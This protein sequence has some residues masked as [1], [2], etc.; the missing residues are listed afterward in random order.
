MITRQWLTIFSLN[1]LMRLSPHREKQRFRE[2][3]DN[4]RAKMISQKLRA[5]ENNRMITASYKLVAVFSVSPVIIS[6]YEV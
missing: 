5:L 2:A 4:G 1:V 6:S 3:E